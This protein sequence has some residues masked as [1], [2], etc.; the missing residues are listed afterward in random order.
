MDKEKILRKMPLDLCQGADAHAQLARITERAHQLVAEQYRILVEEVFP[1]LAAQGIE[2]VTFDTLD[3]SERAHVN[4]VFETS[5]YPVLTPLAVDPGH[6]FPHVH[7]K[8]LNIALLIEGPH[9][10]RTQRLFAVVQV[11]SVL[12]RVMLLP[13][14]G[15]RLRFL[16]LEDLVAA[17]LSEL[18]GGFQVLGH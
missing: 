1:G 4:Q 9:R 10:D 15:E 3:E 16:L 18:F 17:R 12:P 11:P 2:R 6:P 14:G 7:N 8:S 5:V 13:G